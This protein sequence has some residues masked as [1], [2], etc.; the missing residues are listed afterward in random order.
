MG[1]MERNEAVKEAQWRRQKGQMAMQ[2]P[3]TRRL[4]STPKQ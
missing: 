3:R 4:Q 2:A 1:L